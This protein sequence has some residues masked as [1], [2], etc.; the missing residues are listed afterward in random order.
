MEL[1]SRVIFTSA[2]WESA[3]PVLPHLPLLLLV[4]LVLL[5]LL[6]L[7]VPLLLLLL[8]VLLELLLL[9]VPLPAPA[10]LADPGAPGFT[11]C[12]VSLVFTAGNSECATSVLPGNL[13]SAFT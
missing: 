6:V 2:N 5:V 12:P 10:T 7:L 3:T 11:C 13:L 9:L 4:H 8:A 1:L